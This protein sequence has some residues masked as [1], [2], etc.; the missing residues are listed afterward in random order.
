MPVRATRAGG[1]AYGRANVDTKVEFEV[2]ELS[3]AF[4]RLDGAALCC[5]KPVG[6]SGFRTTSAMSRCTGPRR[7]QHRWGGWGVETYQRRN[8]WTE[9]DGIPA[10]LQPIVP[11]HGHHEASV[12][13]FIAKVSPANSLPTAARRR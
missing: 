4:L 1:S 11:E 8:V 12:L 9:I 13:Q 7:R 5:S 3:T 6:P 10:E 2:E